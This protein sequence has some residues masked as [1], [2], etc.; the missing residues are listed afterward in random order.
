[1]LLAVSTMAAA[2]GMGGG[3]G[4]GS[5]GMGSGGMGAMHGNMGNMD[6]GMQHEKAGNAEMGKQD[7]K[8]T[9]STDDTTHSKQDAAKH[10]AMKIDLH[11]QPIQH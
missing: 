2:V 4:M 11:E 6:G 1:M 3:A 8:G 5:G 9:H 10:D 7:G